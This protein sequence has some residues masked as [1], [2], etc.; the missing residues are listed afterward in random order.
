MTHSQE[1]LNEPN[2]L[3]FEADGLPCVMLR[4]LMGAWCGYVGVPSSHPWF[5]LEYISRIKRPKG[6][7]QRKFNDGIG[8]ID[9]FIEVHGGLTYS[10]HLPTKAPD[11]FHWFGFDCAHCNDLVPDMMKYHKSHGI[12][13][14][15]AYVVAECQS[16]AA[17]LQA[18]AKEYAQ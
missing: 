9:L 14:N 4:G 1:W 5:G 2:E 7:D 11:E 17:Q 10:G 3:R 8:A 6:F 12:Y 18:F 16:L 15:Q 13:R